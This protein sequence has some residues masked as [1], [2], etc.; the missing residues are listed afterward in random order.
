MDNFET[1][2]TWV[3]NDFC[4]AQ[5][6]YCPNSSRGGGQPPDIKEYLR[7][8]ELIIDSYV[9]KQGRKLQ[10]IFNGGEPLD[11]DEIV[12]FLKFCRS[13]SQSITLHTNGGK[14]WVDWWALEPYVD[15]LNLTFHHWQ[16]SSLARYIIQLYRSKNKPISVTA[17]VRYSHVKEDLEKIEALEKDTEFKILKTLLYVHGDPTAGLMPYSLDDLEKI[18]ISNGIVKE[19]K[20]QSASVEQKIYFENTTWDERYQDK[21]KSNPSYSGKLCNAGIEQLHIGPQGWV[22]GSSC[23]NSS[24]GNIWKEGWMPLV[25]PQI[26][27]MQACVHPEDQKITKFVN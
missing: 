16:N 18:D 1:A 10:W 19:K 24:L 14:L 12:M 9:K 4:R 15:N 25:A 8:A 3:L 5:C 21:I 20:E 6:T 2:V 27:T 17:P 7:I 26:C 22:S 13:H 23:G 11:M